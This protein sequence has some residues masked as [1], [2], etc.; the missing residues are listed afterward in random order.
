ML[1]V[2]LHRDQID[3]AKQE[4]ENDEASNWLSHHRRRVLGG[5]QPYAVKPPRSGAAN[6]T[7]CTQRLSD[8]RDC[9]QRQRETEAHAEPIHD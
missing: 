3:Q 4:A 7:P 8:D 2:L 9:C 5:K 6:M 1:V